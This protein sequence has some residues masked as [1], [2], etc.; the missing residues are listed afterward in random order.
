MISSYASNIT[1][2]I[3]DENLRYEFV[4]VFPGEIGIVSAKIGFNVGQIQI[5][6]GDFRRSGP[7]TQ[8]RPQTSGYQ[9]VKI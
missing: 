2:Y 5:I 8:K 6:L 1:V 3:S 9:T 4:A 7:P